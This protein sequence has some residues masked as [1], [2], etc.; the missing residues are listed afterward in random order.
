[1]NF[2]QDVLKHKIMDEF[3]NQS[4]YQPVRIR[5]LH[6]SNL[7][8]IVHTKSEGPFALTL[9]SLKQE[10]L[11]SSNL[12]HIVFNALEIIVQNFIFIDKLIFDVQFI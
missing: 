12:A 6:Q 3:C 7:K 10:K 2:S 9:I 1:M 11:R 5:L 4:N 8:Y